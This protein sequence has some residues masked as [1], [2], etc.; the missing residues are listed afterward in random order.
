M[1]NF[2]KIKYYFSNLD[3]SSKRRLIYIAIL[4]MLVLG[5]IFYKLYPTLY[6]QATCFDKKQNGF[7]GGVDCGG[8]CNL[9]CKN[10]YSELKV[11]LQKSFPAAASSSDIMIL[12][13]NNNK[14]IAPTNISVDIDVY[15]LEG[16]FLETINKTT[17][18]GTQKYIPILISNYK[19]QNN[20]S[21][22]VS[23]VFVKNISYDMYSTYGAYDVA[24][25]DYKLDNGDSTGSM[26]AKL[27]IKIKN[28]Y[29]QDINEKLRLYVLLRDELDNI[30]AINY[31]DINSLAF[32]E[33]KSLNFLWVDM[34]KANVKNIDIITVSN[35]YK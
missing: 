17:L 3:W 1:N 33:V 11:L 20:K 8:A 6:P 2:E 15:D 7:E 29:K 19:N 18:A 16:K 24:L 30:V 27:N 13:E 34:I 26:D 9:Q 5:F 10:T 14:N 31:Q 35:L 4:T 23:K 21:G 12:L 22:L 25:I 28:I 32:E